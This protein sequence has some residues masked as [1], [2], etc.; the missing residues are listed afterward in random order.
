[1]QPAALGELVAVVGFPHARPDL[2]G[3]PQV[4]QLCWC[5]LLVDF[6]SPAQT[7]PYQKSQANWCD[8]APQNGKA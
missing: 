5:D 3:Q 1:M 4:T 8:Q 6:V 2:L 7:G